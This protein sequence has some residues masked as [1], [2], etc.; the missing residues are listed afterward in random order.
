MTVEGLLATINQDRL[1]SVLKFLQTNLMVLTIAGLVCLVVDKSNT[2]PSSRYSFL[3]MLILT[4][5]HI[6]FIFVV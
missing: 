2:S 1:G 6:Y 3:T 4:S 5:F